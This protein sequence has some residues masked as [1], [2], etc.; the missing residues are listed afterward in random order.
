MTTKS[1]D[2]VKQANIIPSLQLAVRKENAEGKLVVVGTGKHQVKFISDKVVMGK[3]YQTR[4][5]RHE[6]Q[7]IFEEKGQQKKYNVPVKDENGEVHYLIQRMADIEYG[8][9]ITLEYQRKGLKGFIMTERVVNQEAKPSGEVS[10]DEIPVIEEDEEPKI[11]K[12]VPLVE[13]G[14]ANASDVFEKVPGTDTDEE[15][16]VEKIPF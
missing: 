9:E 13:G 1:Q 5:E 3:D 4:E 7:Y 8:E 15:V 6:V 10:D 14:E 11:I 16:D 2:I 12:K